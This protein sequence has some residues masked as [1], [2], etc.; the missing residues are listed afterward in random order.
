MKRIVSIQD[1]SCIGKCSLT[2]ALPII[3]AMGAECAVLPTAVLSTHTAFKG[4][5]FHDLTEE[6]SPI[7][8]HWEKENM[9]FDAIYTGYLG[10]F[11]QIKLVSDFFLRF[12]PENGVILADPAMADNGRLYPGFTPEFAKTM[13]SLCDLA[14]V[15]VPN[16]TEASFILDI[17]FKGNDYSESDIRDILLRL[18]A[19]GI[20]H[21]ALTGVSLGKNSIGVM[22]Y[23]TERGSF[24]HYE[25]EL[26]P[27][28]F[29][30]TGDVFASCAA[31]ALVRGMSVEDA[32]ALSVDYTLESMRETLSEPDHIWYGVN[33]EAAIPYLTDRLRAPRA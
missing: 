6:I 8:E 31:G 27:V 29:H 14:D 4:F 32:L 26:L 1:I 7:A 23:D 13:G 2:V 10:S 22:S 17:P 21:P 28:S 25:N 19:R 30:G 5:T 3:S 15:V 18:S 9:K 16:L 12:R 33:F 11:A 24:F 20:P